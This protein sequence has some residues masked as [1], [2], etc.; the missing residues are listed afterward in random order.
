M[1]DHV[2]VKRLLFVLLLYYAAVAF[3]ALIPFIWTRDI[4]VD[5]A[6]IILVE[7]SMDEGATSFA[8]TAYLLAPLLDL[9]EL[10]GVRLDTYGYF[11]DY[12][13]FVAN[14]FFG[15][16]S[17]LLIAIVMLTY[18]LP[19][20]FGFDAVLTFGAVVLLG[21]FAFVISKEI[22][23]LAVSAALLLLARVFRWPAWTVAVLYAV[24]L[25]GLSHYFRTYYLVIGVLL[26]ASF[27]F[28]RRSPLLLIGLY[29]A[30]CLYLFVGYS[31]LPLDELN[32]GRASYLEDV[33]ASRIMY[34]LEDDSRLGFALNRTYTFISMLVPLALPLRSIAYAPFALLQLAITFRV[35]QV[36]RHSRDDMTVLAAHVVLA[37]TAVSALFEPDYGSYFR[38]KVGTLLF[39][40]ILVGNRRSA[41]RGD[42]QHALDPPETTT[43]PRVAVGG[44]RGPRGRSIG[45]RRAPSP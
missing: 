2:V 4:Y 15:S 37:F 42:D 13:L 39:L 5:G 38:H 10:V 11:I 28:C 36:I 45:V 3:S 8:V 18:Q 7:P 23:P 21:P 40:V 31:T 16:V 12:D 9:L 17:F 29:T 1:V 35:V 33:S 34:P 26:I 6:K 22:V 27:L 32:T 30:F 19:R 14:A 41:R 44:T 20:R 43:A 25:I 24:A